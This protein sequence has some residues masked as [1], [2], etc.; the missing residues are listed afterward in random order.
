MNVSAVIRRSVRKAMVWIDNE[1]TILRALGVRGFLAFVGKPALLNVMGDRTLGRIY[2]LYGRGIDVPLLCRHGSS[3]RDVFRLIYVEHEYAA[4]QLDSPRLIVDCGANVGY[5]AVYFLSRY[6]DARVVAIEPDPANFALLSCNLAPFASRVRLIQAGIWSREVPLRLARSIFRDGREWATQVHE[7]GPREA[8]EI[9]G[10]SI[11]SIMATE[12]ASHIDL[13]KMD[14]ERSEVVVFGS[15]YE[16]WLPNVNHILIEL[17][18]Q[19][20]EAVFSSAIAARPHHR[21]QMG[22]LTYCAFGP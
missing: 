11:D 8:G 3:D 22:E 10:I 12:R 1:R 18:D 2:R 9:R 5:S 6:P 17:H 19:E 21:E 15:G 13:L 7:T 16:N 20:C 4:L 14:I